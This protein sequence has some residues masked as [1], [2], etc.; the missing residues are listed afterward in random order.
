MYKCLGILLILLCLNPSYSQND[1][2]FLLDTTFRTGKVIGQ[3]NF[4]V[5]YISVDST[6]KN[7]NSLPIEEVKSIVYKDKS[8]EVFCDIM[9]RKKFLGTDESITINYGNR[10]S[11]W[12]DK[13]I[14][15]LM[16]QE[17]KK[18]NSI[19][20][21]LNYMGSEGWQTL[22]TYSASHNSYTIEH[23]IL[24]KEITK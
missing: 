18:Y 8:I 1:T 7:I 14:F 17:L 19:I 23:Y 11:L 15:T 22:R 4:S 12:I 2:I 24:K 21:V 16:T 5:R 3:D 9:S 10:D 20:D 13:K 6:K